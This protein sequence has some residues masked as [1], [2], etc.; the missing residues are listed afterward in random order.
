MTSGP[1]LPKPLAGHCQLFITTNTILVYGGVTVINTNNF[2]GQ[3]TYKTEYSNQAFIWSHYIWSNISTDNPC[4]NNGQ[5]LSL[6]QP[7]TKRAKANHTDIIIVTFANATSCTSIL[8][9][10]TYDWDIVNVTNTNIPIGGHLVTSVDNS[11]VFYMGGILPGQRQALDVYELT[12]TG[13]QITEPKLPYG[14][15]SN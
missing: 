2:M 5:D 4:S 12:Q 8:N 11:R 7:C 15:G 1:D 3:V 14:I 10:V 9:L 13:W 6:Q